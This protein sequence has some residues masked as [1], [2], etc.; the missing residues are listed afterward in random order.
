MSQFIFQNF[1]SVT[2]YIYQSSSYMSASQV[3]SYNIFF[4]Y[5]F[6]PFLNLYIYL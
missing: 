2:L 5:S 3:N 6:T 4:I 1:S